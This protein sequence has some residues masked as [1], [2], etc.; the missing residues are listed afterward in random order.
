MDT[1]SS[2]PSKIANFFIRKG[3]KGNLKRTKSVTKLEKIDRKRAA[4][5][6]SDHES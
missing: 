5:N 4:S 6:L 2:T 3:F 1:S